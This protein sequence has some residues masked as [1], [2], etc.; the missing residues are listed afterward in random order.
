[1][2]EPLTFDDRMTRSSDD[3]VS[4]VSYFQKCNTTCTTIT[5]MRPSKHRRLFFPI[6][7]RAQFP[8][9]SLVPP[10]QLARARTFHAEDIPTLLVDLRAEVI[11]L[12]QAVIEDFTCLLD[13]GVSGRVPQVVRSGVRSSLS[14]SVG[15]QPPSTAARPRRFD[16]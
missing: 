6:V 5:A 15:T 12:F 7:L 2:L 11:H 13:L 10:R 16:Q 9:S 1:M 4:L 14:R 8:D 3:P